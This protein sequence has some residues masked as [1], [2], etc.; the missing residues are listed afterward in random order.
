MPRNKKKDFAKFYDMHF[1]RIYRFVYFRVGSN[2]ELAEDLTQDV[3]VKALDAFERYDPNI[4][5]SAWIFTIARNHI[6]NQMAKVRPQADIDDIENSIHV[7]EEWG[8]KMEFDYDEKRLMAAI[9]QLPKDEA[10]LIRLKYIDGWKF[11]EI[12]EWTNASSGSLRVKAMRVMKKLRT[13]L[14]QK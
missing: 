14:K 10:D 12:A 4:S 11:N 2:K 9:A 3:F 8:E 7:R 13:I 6:I 5:T 1:D